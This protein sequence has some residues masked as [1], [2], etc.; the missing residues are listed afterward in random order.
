MEGSVTFQFSKTKIAF[1][2]FLYS[3]IFMWLIYIIT[4][5]HIFLVTEYKIYA[6][7]GLYAFILINLSLEV[8]GIL[9]LLF[10]DKV[11]LVINESGVYYQRNYFLSYAIPW[12]CITE[13]KTKR[14]KSTQFVLIKVEKSPII[15]EHLSLFT[16]IVYFPLSFMKFRTITI[17]PGLI[18]KSFKEIHNTLLTAYNDMNQLSNTELE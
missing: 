6:V 16:R 10:T 9:P 2:S 5:R 7:V 18:D 12:N 11:A 4:A 3:A 17:R 13:I 15:Y 8:A 1:L 14:V